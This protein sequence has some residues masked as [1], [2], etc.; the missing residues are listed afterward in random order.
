MK[1]VTS[2]EARRNFK[3]IIDRVTHGE[4]ILVTR[5]GRPAALF[6]PHVPAP[7]RLTSL[8]EFLRKIAPIG[9]S[10]IALLMDERRSR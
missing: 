5:R 7:K 4:S 10:S 2:T 6:T 9:T 1:R 3:K 8:A